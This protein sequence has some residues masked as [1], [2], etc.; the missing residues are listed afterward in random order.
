M[1]SVLKRFLASM[2]AISAVFI[3]GACTPATDNPIPTT[4]IVIS[5]IPKDINRTLS[6]STTSKEFYKIYIQLSPG[7]NASAGN[8]AMGEAKYDPED[9][10][11]TGVVDAGA[12][13]TATINLKIP[14]D[15]PKNGTNNTKPWAGTNWF[16]IAAVI[17]PREV[18]NIFDIDCKASFGG[19]SKSSPVVSFDWNT[20]M[21]SK[22][23]MPIGDY[24]LLYGMPTSDVDPPAIPATQGK[25]GVI[26]RDTDIFPILPSIDDPAW[27]LGITG[28]GQFN[29]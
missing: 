14:F 13:Y 9:P 11:A 27:P 17:S 24:K 8:V 26:V 29:N 25:M 7:T 18:N 23:N 1:S 5:G 2:A 3:L 16:A 19:A 4:T 10:T 20:N 15:Y 12:T 21:I 28:W 6:G 22:N